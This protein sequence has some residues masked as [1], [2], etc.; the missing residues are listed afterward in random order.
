MVSPNL[1]HAGNPVPTNTTGNIPVTNEQAN[2]NKAHYWNKD[3]RLTIAMW[4]FSWLTDQGKGGSYENLEQRVEEA[5]QR[6]YNTLRVDCFPSRL[7]QKRTSFDV[8]YNY[9][10]VLSLPRWGQVTN[11]LECNA[12]ER[13]TQLADTCRKHNIWLG[14]DSWE[15]THMMN[16]EPTYVIPEKKEEKM[17]RGFAHTWVKALRLMRDAGIL[18]RAVWVAPMNEVPHFA[19]RCLDSVRNAGQRNLNEGNVQMERNTYINERLKLVNH[20][21][22]EE[23]KEEISNEG[24]P[25]SYSSLGSEQYDCRLTDIYD[26]VDVHYMPFVICDKQAHD[27]FEAMGKGL[28]GG[29]TFAVY[30]N[31][32]L[33]HWSETFDRACRL[34]Y[35]AM[36]RRTKN[37]MVNALRH[38]TLP[39]GKRLQ[40]VITESHGPCYWPDHP[41]VS[42]KWYKLYNADAV[43]ISASLPF[44]GVSISNFAE[45]IFTLW[46]DEDWHRNANLFTLTVLE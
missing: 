8:D 29:S 12:L 38:T 6:G 15:K 26:V 10:K 44:E 14:L 21:I 33:K 17:L 20:W 9:G 19:S 23:V 35:A 37:Y 28:S 39:S 7:L 46:D 31:L 30:E 16:I 22:G 5:A 3:T 36:L 45:P 4:D 41:D 42:W 2:A 43:R 27:A 24:I 32:D 25:L 34:N 11:A 1:L 18:E 40:A 13:L